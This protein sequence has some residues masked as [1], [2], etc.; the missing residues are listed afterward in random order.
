MHIVQ[1]TPEL[2]PIAKVGGLGDVVYG[3]SKELLRQGHTVSC[4]L[5][6]Y[7]SLDLRLLK[8]LKSLKQFTL[9]HSGKEITITLFSAT[10]EG[11][12]LFLI[13][14]PQF[15]TQEIYGGDNEID[16]FFFFCKSIQHVLELKLISYD[17]LHL[18][19]WTTSALTYLIKKPSLL[20]IHNLRYQG[21]SD[22]NPSYSL[23]LSFC[24][25]AGDLNLLKGGIETADC[26]TT[27]SP[28]YAKEIQSIDGSCELQTT[29]LQN[30]SKIHGI[31]NGIDAHF[32]DPG[33]DPH[34]PFHYNTSH[35]SKKT[36]P[37]IKEGKQ[38]NKQALLTKL[39]MAYQPNTPLVS[40]IARL[41]P[42]KSPQLIKHA[43]LS[44]I[45]QKGQ[46]LLLGSS[47]IREIEQ[48]F[49]DLQKECQ[50]SNQGRV[51]ML[52]D[53]SL[54]H[55]IY[56]ASDLFLIP[57]LFEPCGLTQM[58]ALKYGTLPIA[59]ITGGL[60]DTV[61]DV[62]TA[63]IPEEKRNGF[64]FDFPDEEGV[65]WALNRALNYYTNEP[66]KFSSLMLQGMSYDFSWK[67]RTASYLAL[68][69]KLCKK[70]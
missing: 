11:I 70:S 34:L 62:D 15:Q 46:F 63:K 39:G 23:P 64:T 32:W 67:T 7:A 58:I 10:C 43:I 17:V 33:S 54:A 66:E 19:D 41:V 48:E 14:A 28:S 40:T 8:N 13:D 1:A 50:K 45:K 21:K 4:F 36:L 49:Q 60:A 25:D 52:N 57:S 30:A 51:L 68:Y 2:T 65:N 12:D 42:Q 31:L 29:I 56:A 27:V 35:P 24:D 16:R 9:N 53:E 47:P 5:P 59:R 61:F 26:V 38:K 22:W 37:Q 18:H 44:T 20:T 3:L 69:S 55:Q 6:K